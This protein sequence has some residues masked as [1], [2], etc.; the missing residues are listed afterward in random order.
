MA[1]TLV[2]VRHAK[3]DWSGGLLDDERPL[4]ERGRRDAPA[5]GTW[6]AGQVGRI[7][8]VLCS[9]AVRA[10][11]TWQLAATAFDPAPPVRYE[12]R[13]YQAMP[14]DILTILMEL[15]ERVRTVAVVGHN[16]TLSDVVEQLSGQPCELKTSAIAVLSWPGTWTDAQSA[17]VTLDRLHTARG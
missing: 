15:D 5:I 10:R 2:V 13:I 12:E 7:D 6:L 16:P 3:S 8:Q 17:E 9:T 11:Q 14:A 1:R 4:A